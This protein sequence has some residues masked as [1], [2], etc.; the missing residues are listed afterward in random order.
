MKKKGRENKKDT[1]KGKREMKKLNTNSNEVR[2]AIQEHIKNYYEDVNDLKAEVENLKGYNA[3]YT[4]YHAGAYLVQGGCFLCYY[5]DVKDFLN[6]LGINPENKEYT[7]EK[8]WEL[9]KHLIAI[10]IERLVNNKGV[11]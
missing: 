11:K 4:D 7:D 8:S 10:N 5:S 1:R 3:I 2:K 6:G 9:Y